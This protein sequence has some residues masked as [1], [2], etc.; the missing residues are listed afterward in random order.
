MSQVKSANHYD[1][2]SVKLPRLAG[3]A[4]NLFTTL[5]SSSA[6]NWALLGSLLESAGVTQLRQMQVDEAPTMHPFAPYT[7]VLASTTPRDPRT[8]PDLPRARQPG[9]A[10]ATVRDYADAYR[11]GATTPTQVADNVLA[12]I[13]DSNKRT[14]ALRAIIQS[15]REDVLAQARASTQ[16]YR[17]GKP[18]SIFDGVPVAVKDEVDQVPYGTTVGTKFLGKTPATQDATVVARMRAA[19]A[20]LIGK[21]NMHEIGIGVTGL[22]PH[23]GCARNPYNVAHY[24]GGS[25]SGSAAAVAAGLCPVA[26]G[27]DGGGSI[28]IPAAF[29]GIVGLKSTYGRVS[30]T[31]A[32]PLCWSVAHL[33]P[34]AATAEDAALAWA[35]M[36]GPDA[37]DRN[38]VRQ[39]APT[40]DGFE[41]TVRGLTFGIYSSWF[42]HA[43]PAMVEACEKLVQRFEEAGARLVEVEIPELNAARIAHVI[44]ISTEMLTA[45]ERYD[46]A[47]R[48][49]FGLDVQI[50]L[51]LARAFTARDYVQAQ[52]V[53]TR[54][55]A[56]LNQVLDQVDA[57]ITPA[58]GVTAPMIPTDALPKGESDLTTLTEIMRFVTLG[59][60]TGLPAISFPAGYDA[61]GLP[62]GMQVIGRAWQENELLRIARAA[63]QIVERRAPQVHYNLLAK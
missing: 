21:A 5:L 1:L 63:E 49:D 12:A 9:F 7:G 20:L 55:M 42:N 57:I 19:G 59:N 54:T 38:T 60:L 37:H 14:P 35:I 26:L 28:R 50:N 27:A 61:D 46:A 45:M 32:A 51:A 58:T 6:T 56:H 8:L 34:L 23:H 52:R 62:V 11:Q 47:H 3:G 41:R 15:N 24:T 22:N 2:Q 33:G 39:P 25:S 43:T 18:L 31:G 16:R 13:E 30:E 29:C 44:T 53:R 10:F 48:G 40:L 17:D 36:A 4:L